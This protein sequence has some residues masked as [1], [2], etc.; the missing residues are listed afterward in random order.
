MCVA[1]LVISRHENNVVVDCEHLVDK[2]LIDHYVV[3]STEQLLQFGSGHAQLGGHLL[4]MGEQ[5]VRDLKKDN[6]N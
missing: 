4:Q 6:Q 3:Q 5:C 2:R 1:R